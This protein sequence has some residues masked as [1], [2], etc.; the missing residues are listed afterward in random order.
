MAKIIKTY[1]GE[2]SCPL[3]I[4]PSIL[5][6]YRDTGNDSGVTLKRSYNALFEITPV[7]H[8]KD[9]S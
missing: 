1:A 2:S 5:Q 3:K 8:V 7:G 4:C 9:V 6:W